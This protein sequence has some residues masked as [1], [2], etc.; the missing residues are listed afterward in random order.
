[1]SP[2]WQQGVLFQE[3]KNTRGHGTTGKKLVIIAV[4]TWVN[5]E[6]DEEP[7]F[8]RAFVVDD[9]SAVWWCASRYIH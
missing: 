3:E 9:A 1:M 2:V 5:E 8:A 7:G 6:N 4:S